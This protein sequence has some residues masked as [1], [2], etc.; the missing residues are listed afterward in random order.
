ML[1]FI[2]LAAVFAA[3]INL[4]IPVAKEILDLDKKPRESEEIGDN[5]PAVQQRI[6]RKHRPYHA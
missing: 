4:S 2:L 5:D 6:E 1:A 3:L